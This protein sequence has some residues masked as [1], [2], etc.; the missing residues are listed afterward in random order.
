MSQAT[1][2]TND[3]LKALMTDAVVSRD[4]GKSIRDMND[5]SKSGMYMTSTLTANM[6][7]TGNSMYGVVIIF[8]VK[9]NLAVEMFI[10]QNSSI[11][12]IREMYET[13]SGWRKVAL[14]AVTS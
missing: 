10:P 14:S 3:I 1:Q 9:S 11:L 5:I 7:V 4:D 12:Y 8:V 6:P 13:W 2:V